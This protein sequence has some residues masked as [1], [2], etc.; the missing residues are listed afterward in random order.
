MVKLDRSSDGMYWSFGTQ[1]YNKEI[2]REDVK[3]F[4]QGAMW[5]SAPAPRSG[6]ISFTLSSP[7]SFSMLLYPRTC[8]S[9]MARVAT[10][11]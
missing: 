10:K 8:E 6:E 3:F 11:N 7:Y 9:L 4:L 2:F 5:R 1:D